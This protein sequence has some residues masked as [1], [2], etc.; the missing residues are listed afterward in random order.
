M[1]ALDSSRI[2]GGRASPTG[3]VARGV[4]GH[5]TSVGTVIEDLEDLSIDEVIEQFDVTREQVEAILEF[6]AA[7]SAFP[8][9]RPVLI[10]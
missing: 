2:S 9:S 8:K 1:A 6:V 7:E 10:V 3:L 4:H 5:R